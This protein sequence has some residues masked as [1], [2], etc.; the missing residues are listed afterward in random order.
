MG[1]GYSESKKARL[2]RELVLYLHS[3][4][5]T[6][7]SIVKELNN[8]QHHISRN[9]AYEIIRRGTADI[10]RTQSSRIPLQ[11]KKRAREDVVVHFLTPTAAAKKR[12]IS[13]NTVKRDLK[14]HDF[15]Y[16]V[17]PKEIPLKP[18]NFALRKTYCELIKTKNPV[19]WQRRV[20]CTDSTMISREF[21]HNPIMLVVGPPTRKMWSL[22][23]LTVTR[24][25][26]MFTEEFRGLVGPF[27]ITGSINNVVYQQILRNHF[28]P[29]IEKLFRTKP[30]IFQQDNA[31][32]HTTDPTQRWLERHSKENKRMEF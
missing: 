12:K 11:T 26:Y 32:P 2:R 21:K 15:N 31:P 27:I 8:T 18:R 5:H 7:G 3:K 13:V 14:K 17:R 6:A 24:Q 16:F 30:Y 22:S 4:G 23:E 9:A 25:L 10:S 19:Y 29:A 1:G 20:V 28:M